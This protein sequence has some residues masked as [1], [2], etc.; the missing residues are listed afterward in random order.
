[1]FDGE[2]V[3]DGVNLHEESESEQESKPYTGD[4]SPAVAHSV[5]S[6]RRRFGF[7]LGVCLSPPLILH[8]ADT[9]HKQAV[10]TY[11]ARYSLVAFDRRLRI[12][13]INA[14][15]S[16]RH[17]L[18]IEAH[19][20]PMSIADSVVS[21]SVRRASTFE[22]YSG[23]KVYGLYRRPFR[24]SSIFRHPRTNVSS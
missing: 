4:H 21:D 1:V 6:C 20:V 9:K 13:S 23:G 11:L 18:D 3:R 7:L 2:T 16:S 22:R 8:S 15:W 19:R 10:R 5:G 14:P 24:F 12:D 17:A